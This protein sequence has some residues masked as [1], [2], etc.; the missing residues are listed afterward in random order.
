MNKIDVNFVVNGRQGT[1]T[2]I[3]DEK[4]DLKMI[5]D[6]KIDGVDEKSPE[7]SMVTFY[8]GRALWERLSSIKKKKNFSK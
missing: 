8:L 2:A 1:A 5:Y 3:A 4:L 6:V 7:Q